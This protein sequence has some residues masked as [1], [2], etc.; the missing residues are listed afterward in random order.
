MRV[1]SR[2]AVDLALMT[3]LA[4]GEPAHWM[5]TLLQWIWWLDADDADGVEHMNNVIW[6]P[7]CGLCVLQSEHRL[8]L[9]FG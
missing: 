3:F 1:D 8:S 5:R 7:G 9:F 2:H 6:R 4:C